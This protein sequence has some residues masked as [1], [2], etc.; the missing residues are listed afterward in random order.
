M[1]YRGP[2]V[3]H[4]ARLFRQPKSAQPPGQLRPLPVQEGLARGRQVVP[5]HC[6]G[7]C[8]SAAAIEQAAPAAQKAARPAV[9]MVVPTPVVVT[10]NSMYVWANDVCAI[11]YQHAGSWWQP[12]ACTQRPGKIV[13]IYR[14]S[15]RIPRCLAF[16]SINK[17]G[18]HGVRAGS[19]AQLSGWSIADPADG[20]SGLRTMW[21]GSVKQAHVARGR[22]TRGRHHVLPRPHDRARA[23]AAQRRGT[24]GAADDRGAMRVRRYDG[25]PA[26]R[27]GGHGAGGVGG[28]PRR[29]LP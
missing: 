16:L 25:G 1:F 15:L 9:V 28:Q 18:H 26:A 7:G 5:V 2:S 8:H 6:R 12:P 21:G 13:Q 17:S 23:H 14:Y 4:A 29:R 27:R 10:V 22:W 3:G 24:F 11:V 20:P 19:S